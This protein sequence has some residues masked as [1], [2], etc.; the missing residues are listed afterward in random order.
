LS[1]FIVFILLLQTDQ[2]HAH[3]DDYHA[4]QLGRLK[5]RVKQQKVNERHEKCLQG[6]HSLGDAYV[7]ACL[8]GKAKIHIEQDHDRDS[9]GECGN[10]ED[11]HF[12][13]EITIREK[14]AAFWNVDQTVVL[15]IVVH[16]SCNKRTKI[17]VKHHLNSFSIEH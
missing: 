1:V 4:D 12:K 14:H 13:V 15:R 3:K 17:V 9:G 7:K 16:N 8:V 11:K 6:V 2:S 5:H 10:C